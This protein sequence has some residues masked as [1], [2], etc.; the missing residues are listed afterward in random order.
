MTNKHNSDI[1]KGYQP[2]PI[3]EGYMPNVER[4]YQPK[5]ELTNIK[6][7]KGG[8]GAVSPKNKK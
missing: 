8:T 2:K 5:P 1:Q 6:I 7:P 3:N 4:G